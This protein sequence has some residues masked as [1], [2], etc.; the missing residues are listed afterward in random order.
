MLLARWMRKRAARARARLLDATAHPTRSLNSDIQRGHDRP[1]QQERS[2]THSHTCRLPGSTRCGWPCGKPGD[3]DIRV[4]QRSRCAGS[5]H[6][7]ATAGRALDCGKLPSQA[8]TPQSQRS[9]IAVLS[10]HDRL[11]SRDPE[12]GHRACLRWSTTPW[13]RWATRE[14]QDAHSAGSQPEPVRRSLG[15]RAQRG[16]RRQ[17]IDHTSEANPLAAFLRASFNAS[18]L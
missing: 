10:R 5:T 8:G 18:E 11:L 6:R 7:M 17:R 1:L 2:E 12:S 15:T 13:I 14:R 3:R 9:L 16:S 4:L